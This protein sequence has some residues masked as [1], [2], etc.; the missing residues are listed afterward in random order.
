MKKI[1]SILAII[2]ISTLALAG[3]G[4]TSGPKTVTVST[5]TKIGPEGEKLINHEVTEYQPTKDN[6]IDLSNIFNNEWSIFTAWDDGKTTSDSLINLKSHNNIK[7]PYA[8]DKVIDFEYE[9]YEKYLGK[10]EYNNDTFNYEAFII[11]LGFEDTGNDY[12]YS[13]KDYDIR[14]YEGYSL[15][16]EVHD[17]NSDRIVKIVHIDSGPKGRGFTEDVFGSDYIYCTTNHDR[18]NNKCYPFEIK[19]H[20][21]ILD[22]LRYHQDAFIKYPLLGY[23]VQ[24]HDKDTVGMSYYACNIYYSVDKS[25]NGFIEAPAWIT[26]KK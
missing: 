17:K 3:C 12:V 22:E 6:D 26:V 14:I 15:T 10:D 4:K 2:T 13:T 19:I 18:V 9:G 16:F 25:N 8:I 5:T 20:C 24:V 21:A 1:S 23:Q 11:D 7:T